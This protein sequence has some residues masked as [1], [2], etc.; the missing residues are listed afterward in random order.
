MGNNFI[1]R[2][3]HKL[4]IENKRRN[5]KNKNPSIIANN[6]NGG[7][8]AHDL[9][10]QFNSPTVNIGIWSEDYLKFLNN[11]DYYLLTNPVNANERFDN[12]FFFSIDDVKV[13]FNHVDSAEEGLL[14]WER[15]KRRF[16]RSKRSCFNTAGYKYFSC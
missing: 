16:N 4:Y 14:N 11:L 12:G 1:A 3:E 5:L 13:L 9:G 2:A 8:I 15:R 10:L 7:I 6:C